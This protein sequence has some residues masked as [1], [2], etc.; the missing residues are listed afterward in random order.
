MR[1]FNNGRWLVT[2]IKTCSQLNW[3]YLG[4]FIRRPENEFAIAHQRKV[5]WT[6]HTELTVACQPPRTYRELAV[7]RLE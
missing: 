6:E 3:N 2:E 7:S 5:E 1:A 4:L